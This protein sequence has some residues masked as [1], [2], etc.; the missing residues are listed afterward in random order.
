MSFRVAIVR[1]TNLLFNNVLQTAVA[2]RV[3][4]VSRQFLAHLLL[5]N[6]HWTILDLAFVMWRSSVWTVT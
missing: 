6:F 5:C 4:Y 1:L 2:H 3:F